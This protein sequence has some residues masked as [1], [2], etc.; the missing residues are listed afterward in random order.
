MRETWSETT[1]G[2][3]MRLDIESVP[4]EPESI[5]D[6]VGVFNRGR[7][8]LGRGP[9]AGTA[10]SYKKLNRVRPE[11]VV[12]SRLKAF[13]GAI[14]VVPEGVGVTFA[15]SEF[16]TFTC[17]PD[18]LPTY[19]RLLTTSPQFWAL[20]QGASKGMGG[21]RERVKPADFLRIPIALPTFRAQQGIVEVVGAVDDQINAL[22]AEAERA[23]SARATLLD[24]L[25]SRGGDGWV[26]TTL[27][28]R[29]S[30]TRGRRF[31]KADYSETGLG[32][33]HY[34]QIYTH[35]GA[36]ATQT[37]T[38]LPGESRSRM[39]LARPGDLIIAGTSENV[40]DVGKAVAWLGDDDVAVHDDCY[41]YR[42]SLDPIF[43]SHLFAS[44]SFQAQKVRYVSE[45]KV[46]RISAANIAQI[47]VPVPPLPEQERIA[48]VVGAVDDHIAALNRQSEA[49]RN[50]RMGL[51]SA[52][53]NGEIEIDRS[54]KT[55]A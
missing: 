3:V 48:E 30:L 9:I 7:G 34:G 47:S 45:T 20:L 27:G 28:E 43:A 33:I 38:F 15:S 24:E 2:D 53:L 29:G 17:G 39:R 44:S 6:I 21:R 5:Y 16:P 37:V 23:V 25:L 32:C 55:A 26:A 18:L 1:L 35:F 19:F 52:F 8:L 22:A 12:Y 11:Q 49:L 10:T 51:L 4:V 42:H 41:I 50:V 36:T 46:V 13:E 14:T 40:Q 54:E 31:T